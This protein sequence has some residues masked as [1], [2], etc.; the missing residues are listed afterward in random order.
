LHHF[1]DFGFDA[2]AGS[3]IHGLIVHALFSSVQMAVYPTPVKARVVDRLNFE[4]AVC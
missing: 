1:G 2:F 4:K 3:V